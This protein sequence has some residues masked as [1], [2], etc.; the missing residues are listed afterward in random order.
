[1]LTDSHLLDDVVR[2]SSIL[3]EIRARGIKIAIDDFGTGYSS[4]T[5]LQKLPVDVVKI[6]RSFI[7][8]ATTNSFDSTIIDTIVTI[9]RAL[10]L[11]IVAEGIETVEQLAYVI[12]AGATQGQGFLMARPMPAHEAEAILFNGPLFDRARVLDTTRGMPRPWTETVP[13]GTPVS[14]D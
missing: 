9:G 3:A 7:S 4:M 10:D 14:M 6:D 2:A 11:E 8:T 12:D 5:Y 1:E 13:I